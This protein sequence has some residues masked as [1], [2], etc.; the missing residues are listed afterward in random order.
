MYTG[1]HGKFPL[2]FADFNEAL[3]FSKDFHKTLKNQ[4]SLKSV[5]WEP[6]SSMRTDGRTDR[7]T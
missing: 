1:L 2:F 3:T 4:I 7:H 5:L 6:S